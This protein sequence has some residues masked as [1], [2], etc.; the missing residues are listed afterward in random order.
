MI[1]ERPR[2]AA[3]RLWSSW[4]PRLHSSALLTASRGR[5]LTYR[6]EADKEALY[7]FTGDLEEEFLELGGLLRKI[8]TL[9][10]QV[11]ERSNEVMT[12]ASGRA[13]D[14]AIQF[15]FQLLKKAEDLVQAGREQHGKVFAVFERMQTDLA[16]VARER[17]ALLRTLS[18]LQTTITQFRI[19]A[20]AFDESTRSQFFA[21]AE[22]IAAIVTDVQTAVV[23][24]F[25]ELERTGAATSVLVTDLAALAAEQK[26]ETAQMLIESRGHLSALNGALLSS[27]A[28]AQSVSEAGA[29]I[30][31]GVATAIVALQCQ[32]MARQ[33]FQHI[34]AAVDEMVAHLKTAIAEG[35][36]GAGEADCRRFLADAGRLQ[37][38]QLQAVFG[39]LDE[40]A[41]Q[42]GAGLRQ[43]ESE[44]ISLAGHAISAGGA[45]LDGKIIEQAIFSTQAALQ[46][47]HNSVAS[48]RSVGD[49]VETLKSTF[50]DCT[51]QIMELALRLRRVALNA[52]I[53]AA[54]VKAGAALEVVASN[55]RSIA[56]EAM[57]QLGEISSRVADLVDLVVDLEQRLG[58]YRELADMEQALLARE[59][60]ESEEKLRCLERDLRGVVAA[61]GPLERELSQT[62]RRTSES[63]RFPEAVALARSR[64]TAL[65]ERIVDQ[66]SDSNHDSAPTAHHK[67][68]EL[69]NNY[70]MAH[71]HAVHA[72]ALETSASPPSTFQPCLLSQGQMN[73]GGQPAAS[74]E[75]P[76]SGE[77]Q[78]D[79]DNIADGD[80]KLA[81]NVELF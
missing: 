48:V 17:S 11:R 45:A 64:S 30:A 75:A 9:S 12:A 66:Y 18:P 61:I 76:S 44:A 63:V 25:E 80:D 46:I 8:T 65:F 47:I 21:L 15:A 20:C 43:I 78:A 4:L 23:Q 53:F 58:D 49:L 57:A 2:A 55:T 26:R 33:K 28:A 69:K 29:R 1:L 16:Q 41:S 72:S 73:G 27:E 14:A 10:R 59:A 68:L 42:V 54:H 60:S 79:D 5:E 36:T 35:S 74:R 37:L 67:V 56:D 77:F 3:G 51:S 32:D 19:Q 24:R 7:K 13:E 70:T 40:A 22:T 62:I 38:S 50:S 71:E 52:Q 39:Q 6:L 81:D 34:G 31:S